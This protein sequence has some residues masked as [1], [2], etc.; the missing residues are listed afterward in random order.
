MFG[1]YEA[2]V[3]YQ[4][5]LVNQCMKY[6]AATIAFYTGVFDPRPDLAVPARSVKT[7]YAWWW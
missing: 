6:F 4:T 2:V 3:G 5:A 1:P 7:P